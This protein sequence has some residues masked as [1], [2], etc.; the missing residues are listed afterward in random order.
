MKRIEIEVL[1][2]NRRFLSSGFAKPRSKEQ[3]E[4]PVAQA[5]AGSNSVSRIEFNLLPTF[6]ASGKFLQLM[7]I[8]LT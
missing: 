2:G 8:M 1:R 5:F 4:G 7:Q 6:L 3:V